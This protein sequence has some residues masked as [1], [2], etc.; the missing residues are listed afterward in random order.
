MPFTDT[1]SA[2][3]EMQIELLRRAGPVRRLQTALDWSEMTIRLSR[4]GLTRIHPDLS[5]E[6]IGLLFIEYNY[7]ASLASGV[8]E[9]LRSKKQHEHA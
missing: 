1:S 5:E 7:G 8:R 9:C 6:D 3:A 2:M 4:T